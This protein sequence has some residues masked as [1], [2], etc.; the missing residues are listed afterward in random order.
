MTTKAD[1]IRKRLLQ[2]DIDTLKA[3]RDL[4]VDALESA[5]KSLLCVVAELRKHCPVEDV[6]LETIASAMNES[7][8]G[9]PKVGDYVPKPE[10]T[11]PSG[12]GAAVLA[13]LI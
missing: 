13:S 4:D 6:S 10:P 7:G 11:R 1:F 3:G 12:N 8:H 9:G 2:I 5:H